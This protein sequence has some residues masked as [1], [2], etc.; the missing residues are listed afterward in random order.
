MKDVLT[1]VSLYLAYALGVAIGSTRPE[2]YDLAEDA[3]IALPLLTIYVGATWYVRRRAAR[4][5][6]E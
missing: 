6:P 4:R 2:T 1:A 3:G 5:K